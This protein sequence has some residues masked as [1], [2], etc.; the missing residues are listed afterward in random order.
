MEGKAGAGDDPGQL[1][2]LRQGGLMGGVLTNIY[3]KGLFFFY[4]SS[5][6]GLHIFTN[7]LEQKVGGGGQDNFF[8]L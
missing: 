3:V 5:L 6:S 4:R 2:K 1:K 7:K 8:C